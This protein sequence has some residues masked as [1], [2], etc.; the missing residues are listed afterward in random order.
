MFVNENQGEFAQNPNLSSLEQLKRAK[1][2]IKPHQPA[3]SVGQRYVE[4]FWHPFKAIIAPALKEDSKPAWRT[5]DYY[6]HPSQLWKLHQDKSKLV[7]LRFDDTTRYATIDLDR[8][9]DYHNHES[10]KRIKAAL[11]DIGIVE[12][13]YLQSSFS[14]GYHLLIPF[15]ASFPTFALACA[16]EI[17]LKNA[18]FIIRQGHLEIFP[19]AKPYSEKEITNYNAIRCPMQ[20]D[21]GSLL[22]DEDLQPISDDVSTFLDHCDRAAVRQDLQLLQRVAQKARRKITRERYRTQETAKGKQWRAD[23]EEIIATGWTG[24]GQTNTLLQIITGYGIVFLDL[25]GEALVKYGVETA[26]KAP[27]YAQYCRHQHE[28]EARVRQWVECTIRHKWYTPYASYP[29]R[30]VGTFAKT[31]A[32]AIALGK[33][34]K[35]KDNIIPLN[36]RF[37]RNFERSQKAIQRIKRVVSGLEWESRLPNGTTERAKL[38]SSEYKSRFNKTLSQETLRKHIHLWHPKWY[39]EDPWLENIYKPSQISKDGQSDQEINQKKNQSVQNPCQIE[40]YGHLFYMKVLCLP[41]ADKAPQGLLSAEVSKQTADVQQTLSDSVN[42]RSTFSSSCSH[43]PDLLKGLNEQCLENNKDFNFNSCETAN[44]HNQNLL[45]N[46]GSILLSV[47]IPITMPSETSQFASFSEQS[48]DDSSLAA[49]V[50][51]EDL[52]KVTKLRVQ[53]VS[54]A[55]RVARQYCLIERRLIGG[56]ERERLEQI[57]KMQFYLDSGNESLIAEAQAWAVLNPG[58]L[59]LIDF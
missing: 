35:N 25:E 45:I 57:A 40:K 15:D 26:K 42:L 43:S 13:I 49:T 47:P 27:G 50:G 28:I 22:L 33:N 34:I 2:K 59:P 4:R 39:I 11:E 18:G 6:L 51:L 56:K 55:K 3:D 9:G 32:E 8:L 41:S 19:N 7:G 21:S 5:I 38:I 52:K 58:C 29:E 46:T 36:G 12:L 24:L 14:G 10:V 54:Y 44:S 17:T 53:A 48:T 37:A 30:L 16:L 1:S 23:W 31:Y 20:P